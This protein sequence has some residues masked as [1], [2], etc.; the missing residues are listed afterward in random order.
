MRSSRRTAVRPPGR[1]RPGLQLRLPQGPVGTPAELRASIDTALADRTGG[2]GASATWVLSNHDVIRHASRL[3]ACRTAATR[4]P[5]CS[6]TAR[7]PAWTGSSGLRRA[8]AA[9]LLMLALPGSAYVYQGEELGLPEVADLARDSLQ[10]PMWDRSGGRLKG[11][12]GC[13]VPLPWRREGSSYG[14]GAG[15]SWLPQ[16]AGFGRAVRRGAGGSWRLAP[17][18]C[19]ARRWPLRRRLLADEALEWADATA[20][21]PGRTA[22]PP[23]GRLASAWPTCRT[24]PGRCRPARCCCPPH[25]SPATNCRRG[26][27]SGCTPRRPDPARRGDLSGDQRRQVPTGAVRDGPVVAAQQQPGQLRAPGPGRRPGRP[28][29]ASGRRAAMRSGRKPGAMTY[30]ATATRAHALGAQRPHRVLGAGQRCGGERRPHGAPT[31]VPPLPRD[32]CDHCDRLRVGGARRGQHDPGRG[33]GRRGAARPRTAAVPGRRSA[34]GTGRAPR[35]G[36]RAA[37]AGGR[38]LAQ[39]RRDVGLR[40]EGAGQQQRER[41]HVPYALRRQ[42]TPAPAA[43]TG[44]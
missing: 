33:A 8:L 36:G 28:R 34:A 44:R 31:G 24:S 29:P 35:P 37:A 3:R 15:G 11:R 43:P 1:T 17:W 19:T 9:T 30:G 6:P 26:R 13:R 20:D 2:R 12:D 21:R 41:H 27:R 14:F 38:R 40:V 7:S 10:D 22:L 16:P 18:S 25:R 23:L 39:H 5:G 32:F 4:R 42:A